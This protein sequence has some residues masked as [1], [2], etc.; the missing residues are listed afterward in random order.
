MK[1][2]THIWT[3]QNGKKVPLAIME[4][5]HLANAY[6]RCWET[7]YGNEYINLSLNSRFKDNL[8]ATIKDPELWIKRFEQE[9][10]K[11]KITLKKPSK[12]L[13]YQDLSKRIDRKKQWYKRNKDFDEKFV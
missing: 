5:N 1:T 7:I 3:T 8:P 11:R 10:E 12:A 13:Y 2:V 6:R 9:A 4:P